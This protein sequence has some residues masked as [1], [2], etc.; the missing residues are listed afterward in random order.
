MG[1]QR[2]VALK[3]TAG[4]MST[5]PNRGENGQ[6]TNLETT[7]GQHNNSPV[8]IVFL[9]EVSVFIHEVFLRIDQWSFRKY[10]HFT[11]HV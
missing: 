6:S 10:Q 7:C 11:L 4:L 3:P 9:D 1:Q 5:C 8:A 2:G